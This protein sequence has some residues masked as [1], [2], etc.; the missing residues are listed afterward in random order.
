MTYKSVSE[1]IAAEDRGKWQREGFWFDE[2]QRAPNHCYRCPG[3][4]NRA[5]CKSCPYARRRQQ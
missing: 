4:R 5:I 1:R 3:I 2:E